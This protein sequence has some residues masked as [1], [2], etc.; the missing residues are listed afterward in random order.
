[1]RLGMVLAVL[2]GLGLVIGL[3][4]TF[5]EPNCMSSPG[6]APTTSERKP[7]P[8]SE[9]EHETY[10]N[11]RLMDEWEGRS[12]VIR[13]ERCIRAGQKLKAAG[14][15]GITDG[16]VSCLGRVSDW[17]RAQTCRNVSVYA[18]DPIASDLAGACERLK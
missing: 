10:L 14:R 3:F 5:A 7:R 8:Y 15:S 11:R 17:E 12:P 9:A 6:K 18:S 1:M 4:G 2:I 16:L 13:G